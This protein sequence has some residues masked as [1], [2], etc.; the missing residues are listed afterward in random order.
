[1]AA[2]TGCEGERATFSSLSNPSFAKQHGETTAGPELCIR[3][4]TACSRQRFGARVK[5]W[6]FWSPLKH[7]FLQCDFRGS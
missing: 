6:F 3:G 4:H 5:K 7:T 2:I 1:M